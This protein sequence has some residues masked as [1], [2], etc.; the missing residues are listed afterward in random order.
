M[1]RQIGPLQGHPE[2]LEIVAR[3]HALETRVR[4]LED[5]IRELQSQLAA[6]HGETAGR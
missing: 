3:L 4:A 2:T 6:A 1:G 5:L